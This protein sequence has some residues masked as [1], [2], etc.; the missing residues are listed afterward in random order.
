M[1]PSRRVKPN[2]KIIKRLE[3]RIGEVTIDTI[4]FKLR[5]DNK[6]LIQALFRLYDCQTDFE[7]D[8]GRTVE[9]N[10]EGFNS[11]DSE[12]LSS[13][14][15]QLKEKGYLTNNQMAITRRRMEKYSNQLY[16]MIINE[17]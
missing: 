16:E 9:K 6:W 10:Y 1:R 7:K 11:M 8:I 17:V 15:V 3:K 2:R 4:R 12:L 13:F 5:F 14:V